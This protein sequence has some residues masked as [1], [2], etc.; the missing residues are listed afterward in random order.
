MNTQQK[1]T[2]QEYLSSIKDLST[3]DLSAQLEL[4][5]R[6]AQRSV[7]HLNWLSQQLDIANDDAEMISMQHE[8]V[9]RLLMGRK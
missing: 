8:V 1:N 3:E 7:W 9:T 5:T 2:K 6:N 4:I